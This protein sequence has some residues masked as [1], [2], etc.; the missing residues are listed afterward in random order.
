SLGGVIA[1]EMARQLEAEGERAALVLIDSPA[2]GSEGGLHG[3]LSELD[4]PLEAFMGLD[5]AALAG[6][7]LPEMIEALERLPPS[8]RQAYLR[9]RAGP[10]S[11]L[12]QLGEAQRARLSEVFRANLTALAAYAPAPY[13][14]RLT[15]IRAARQLRGPGAG[16]EALAGAT[17]ALRVPGHHYSM[18]QPPYVDALAK[19]LASTLTSWH[20]EGETP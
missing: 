19:Q 6:A 5:L 1:F 16:W 12:A 9:E 15:L 10:A 11:P 4:D 14:G 18:M 17:R 3:L 13:G 2:P 20:E 7:E 8:A